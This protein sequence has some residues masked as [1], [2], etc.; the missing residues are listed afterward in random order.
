[1]VK[2]QKKELMNWK[3]GLE[4]FSRIQNRQKVNENYKREVS[5]REGRMRAN[6]CCLIGVLE[7]ENREQRKSNIDRDA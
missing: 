2:Q 4:K 7:E 3:V 5:D 1:M 6:I